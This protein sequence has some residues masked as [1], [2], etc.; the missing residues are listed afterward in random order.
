MF[1]ILITL[2][3]FETWKCYTQKWGMMKIEFQLCNI[4]NEDW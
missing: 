4:C 2:T 3:R 1:V